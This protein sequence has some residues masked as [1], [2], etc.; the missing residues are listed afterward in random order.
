[1]CGRITC[2]QS[3]LAN[4]SAE[5]PSERHEMNREALPSPGVRPPPLARARTRS[6]SASGL[7]ERDPPRGGDVQVYRSPPSLVLAFAHRCLRFVLDI[8]QLERI[9]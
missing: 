2:S 3:P 1:M 9:N 5:N 6:T 8:V 7:D 4:F